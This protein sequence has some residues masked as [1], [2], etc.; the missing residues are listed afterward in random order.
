MTT[1]TAA[2]APRATIAHLPALDGLRGLAVVAVLLFHDDRL[3][4]GYLG[5]DPAGTR[6]SC[7]AWW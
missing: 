4:G 3:V 5:V 1:G 6:C 2:K 7:R